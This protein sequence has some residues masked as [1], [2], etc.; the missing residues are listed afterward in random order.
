MTTITKTAAERYD[1]LVA[2]VE[3]AGG[4][5]HPSVEI[6][7]DDDTEGSLRVRPGRSLAAG[8]PVVR[9]PLSRSLSFLNAVCGHPDFPAAT[10]ASL[11]VAAPGE[12]EGYLPATFLR[13]TPPHVVGRVFLV[14]QY[15]LGE[16]SAWAPYIKTLPQPP[17]TPG[18]GDGTA[19][20]RTGLL[21]CAWPAEDVD[22]LRGTNAYIAVQEINA[23]LEAE[24]AA[25]IELLSPPRGLDSDSGAGLGNTTTKL[26]LAQFTPELYRW[27]YCIFASRSFRQSL[28]I[29][30]ASAPAPS[31]SAGGDGAAPS[32]LTSKADDFSVLL[33]LF[34]MGNHH[35]LAKTTWKTPEDIS[36]SSSGNTSS[37]APLFCELQTGQPYSA[38]QQVYNNYGPGKTNA[39]LLL[40]Y[41][42]VLAESAGFHNDY[43]H[44]RTRPPSSIG[45]G[46]AAAAADNVADH[47]AAQKHLASTHLVSLHPISDPSSLAGRAR[48]LLPLPLPPPGQ[49]EAEDSQQQRRILA[50]YTHVQDSLVASLYEMVCQARGVPVPDGSIGVG[51]AAI[52]AGEIPEELTDEIINALGTK[53]SIDLEKIEAAEA[54]GRAA[55]EN[56]NQELAALYRS[57]CK[58]VLENALASLS[59][60][61][62][63][64][65]EEETGEETEE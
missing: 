25:A 6:Y 63:D 17:H 27:A 53:L 52:L 21:P 34:D 49:E 38:G 43:V 8:D 26:P 41:G 60:E 18:V 37:G 4:S 31:S 16:K 15:L 57:Q 61:E 28:T 58:R 33:P 44:V 35:P 19:S 11:G 9:L 7:N 3:A 10:T 14:Q 22:F 13:G 55:P 39:E 29:P 1:A 62:Y 51:M 24:Y 48:L 36:S 46:P 56:A 64:E 47:D 42:F 2:W 20:R 23:T 30:A 59:G 65:E 54:D 40:G 45:T 5:L 12:A 50:C 32:P